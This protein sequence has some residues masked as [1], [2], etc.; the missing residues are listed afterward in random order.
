MVSTKTAEEH[1]TANNKLITNLD[2]TSIRRLIIVGVVSVLAL[3]IAIIV[4]ATGPTVY[5]SQVFNLY[6]CPNNSHIYNVDTCQG[7]PLTN[8]T[9]WEQVMP[10]VSSL[11]RFW[12]LQMTPYG[13]NLT[14]SVYTTID[15]QV[16]IEVEVNA[17][18]TI[19][20]NETVNQIISCD[21]G[22]SK[23]NTITLIDDEKL[24][25][26]IYVVT[27]YLVNGTNIVGD[28]DFTAWKAHDQ[29]SSFEIGTHLSL[30]IVSCVAV[31]VYLIA[32]RHYSLFVWTF[33]Q[34]FLFLLF[35]VL[36]LSNNPFYGLQYINDGWFFPFLNAFFSI[37]F[38]STFSLYSLFVLDRI[39]LEQSKFQMNMATIAKFIIVG[40]F[41][42]LGIILFTWL[43]IR[44]RKDPI[45]GPAGSASGITGLLYL[46][47]TIFIAILLWIILLII[48]TV[49]VVQG[50]KYIITKFAF[51]A[52]PIIV[53]IISIFSGIFAGTFGPL[54]PTS[55]SVC[56]FNVLNNVFVAV[57]AYSYWPSSNPFRSQQANSE[58][59][60]LFPPTDL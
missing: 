51:T 59:E 43:N 36:I 8:N 52:V 45:L 3:L 15:I 53:Y 38:L 58:E 42:L 27:V 50:K 5:D 56:Y 9:Q 49:P 19:I 12:S 40:I 37:C 55:L 46:V 10:T 13:N 23:C 34:K 14:S 60:R 17:N 16:L 28:I 47:A 33:E 30:M 44:D 32:M 39:R 48:I 22:Y 1:S 11:S 57:I 24:D 20:S 26:N 18:W 41:A 7:I 21:S 2:V 31:F 25:Y 35:F 54:N 29:F 6:Q 4:G